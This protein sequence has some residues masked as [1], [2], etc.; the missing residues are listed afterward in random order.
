MK[1]TMSEKQR[2]T[3]PRRL[4]RTF[5]TPGRTLTAS[6][7]FV[8]ALCLLASGGAAASP[9]SYG[10]SGG[11]HATTGDYTLASVPGIQSIAVSPTEMF[12]TTTLNCT[13][14]LSV[15]PSGTVSL[16]AVLPIPVA[17]CGEG[18]IA[19]APPNWGPSSGGGGTLVSASGPSSGAGN[20]PGN[21]G[22]WGS[23]PQPKGDCGCNNQQ[24]APDTLWDAQEG[25]LFEISNGGA[26]VTLFASFD[27]PAAI[28]GLTYDAVGSFGHDLIVIAGA[29][30]VW[31]VNQTGVV[32]LVANLDLFIEGPAVAPWSF[33]A[34]GGDLLV[35]HQGGNTVYAVS[36]TGTVTPAVTW[37]LA[38]SVAFPSDC[39]C[40]F[41][42]TP[43]VF[44]VANVTA[45]TIEA[46]P[47][48]FFTTLQGVGFVSGGAD[49]GFASFNPAGTTTTLATHTNH[50]EQ[51]T[52][53]QCFG[54]SQSYG[55]GGHHHHHHG[56]HGGHE[57]NGRGW[58]SSSEGA[59]GGK[60]W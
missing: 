16:Y 6:G 28:L 59:Q 42:A 32:T 23:G 1:G 46:F 33:G 57:C 25:K 41:G 3:G 36:P 55:N 49:T 53:V 51:I 39:D 47:A 18:A 31:T 50:L 54:S 12:A 9:V 40:G 21:P 29:G 4:G 44:F 17:A 27:P 19:L 60:G 13:Q 5:W 43:A 2:P 10:Y 45:G 26:T 20:Y 58:P 37:P 22:N 56:H 11:S 52:F 38:E 14:V 35:A 24:S 8:F 48:S 30:D 34:Y 15:S 7:A